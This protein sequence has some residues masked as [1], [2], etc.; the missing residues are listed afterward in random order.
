MGQVHKPRTSYATPTFAY[1]VE[2]FL[3]AHTAAGAWST[4]TTAKYRQTLTALAARLPGTAVGDDVAVLDTE[5][6][7]AA[8][9]QAYTAA[10]D[11]T[12]P[13]TRVRH[14]S[15]L[16]SAL[17]WWRE[18]AGW[19]AGD[20]TARAGPGRK[21]SVDTTRAL[22]RD[23]VAAL[24]RLDVGLRDKTLWQLLYETAAR[25]EEILTLD[26]GDLDLGSKRA[27]VVSKGGKTEWVFWQTGAAMLLPRLLAGRIRGPVFLA[28]RKPT[29]AVAAVDLRPV[30]GR[31][32]LSYR[33]AAEI[34]EHATRRLADPIDQAQGF[35]LRQLRHAILTHEAENGTNTATLL[36]RSRHASVRS[37][38]RYARLGPE[39]VAA[40]DP[41]ARRRTGQGR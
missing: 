15:T 17:T 21:V 4:G 30:T 5:P 29:R 36:A 26:V 28:D 14:L 13:A 31:A 32:R 39:A 33:R 34:F 6:G 37:L 10:F 22:T 38:E 35:T 41:A 8:L 12:S 18:P 23:Q 19:I 9:A 20:P 25:A 11:A 7:V 24:W 1:A 27:R 16:R 3:V 2:T 40:T